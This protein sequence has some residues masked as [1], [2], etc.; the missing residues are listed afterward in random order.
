MGDEFGWVVDSIFDLIQKFVGFVVV[1][2]L[3]M[4]WSC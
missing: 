4:L 3:R 1:H 2:R